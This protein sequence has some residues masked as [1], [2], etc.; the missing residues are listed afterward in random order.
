MKQGN[1]YNLDYKNSVNTV[2][3]TILWWETNILVY[4]YTHIE[5]NKYFNN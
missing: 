1:L 3:P 5:Y 2:M 4:A